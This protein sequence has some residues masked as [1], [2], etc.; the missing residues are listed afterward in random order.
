[1]DELFRYLREIVDI[2]SVTGDEE[3]VAERV[4]SDLAAIG[5]DVEFDEAAPGRPNLIARAGN[6]PTRLWYCTHLDTVPPFFP[7][8][9]TETHIVGRGSCDAKG[10]LA[11]MLFAARRLREDGVAGFGLVFTV[12]EEVDSAGAIHLDARGPGAPVDGLHLVCGEP[13]EGIMAAGHKGT[14]RARIMV[15]GKAAHSS[16]PESGDSAIHRLLAL[17]AHLQSLDWGHSEVLGSATLNVGLISGGVA[18]NVLAPSAEATLYWRL[19]G[20]AEPARRRLEEILSADG[21]L[22]YEHVG[23]NDA[24]FCRTLPGFAVASMSYSTD[25]PFM[26]S[27]GTPLLIGPGSI[28][29][30]HTAHEHVLKSDLVDAVGYYQKIAHE[31]L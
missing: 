13:T 15:R 16:Y 18:G 3:A 25:I 12:G 22:S 17:I 26:P 27:W 9:E 4:G 10:I 8:S 2:P 21:N 19:V 11:A 5:L 6:G 29:D 30:A 1:M 14:L 24:V 7:S 23:Q 28:H 20:E 31:L